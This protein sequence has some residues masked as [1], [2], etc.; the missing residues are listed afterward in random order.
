MGES[1]DA[2]LLGRKW[3][4]TR[5]IVFSKFAQHTDRFMINTDMGKIV[6][7]WKT[8]DKQEYYKM[9]LIFIQKVASTYF[10]LSLV[11]NTARDSASK[12]RYQFP[13]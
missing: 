12:A 2:G 8:G 1:G 9:R 7:K 3:V 4:K 10:I 11:R 5:D 6:K 13:I